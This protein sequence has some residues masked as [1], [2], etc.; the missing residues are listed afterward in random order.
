MGTTSAESNRK[1]RVTPTC[2]VTKSVSLKRKSEDS[3]VQAKWDQWLKSTLQ[4]STAFCFSPWSLHGGSVVAFTPDVI[5][6][7]GKECLVLVYP[8]FFLLF[9]FF[10]IFFLF[11]HCTARGSGYP[12]TYTLQLHFSPTLSSVATWVSRQSSQCYSAGS[13]CKSILSCIW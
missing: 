5:P 13:P 4:G 6:N 3:L 2:L 8:F 7:N 1:P 12:Y 9:I 11:S 10:I